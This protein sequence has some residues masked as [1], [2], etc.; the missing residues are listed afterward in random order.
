MSE[1]RRGARRDSATVQWLDDYPLLR[2]SLIFCSC[3]SIRLAGTLQITNKFRHFYQ[4]LLGVR[5]LFRHD[6]FLPT[7]HKQYSLQHLIGRSDEIDQMPSGRSIFSR[8]PV[9]VSA[10]V[11]ISQTD[12]GLY[13]LVRFAKVAMQAITVTVHLIGMLLAKGCAKLVKC[14]VTVIPSLAAGR[15]QPRGT[16]LSLAILDQLV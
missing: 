8:E 12:N 3:A 6:E 15:T 2:A 14:T 5:E 4:H 9:L 1:P 16:L 11:G 7:R 10:F 13:R